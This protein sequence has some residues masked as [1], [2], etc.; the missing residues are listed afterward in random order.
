MIVGEWI[1]P[2]EV[3]AI[4]SQ[5]V[6][7][8]P[9]AVQEVWV[10]VEDM[11]HH[12]AVATW[13]PAAAVVL[14]PA[15][16]PAVS[17]HQQ[18]AAP[19]VAAAVHPTVAVLAAPMAAAVAA[20]ARPTVAAV[21]LTE[22]VAARR[23]AHAVAAAPIVAVAHAAVPAVVAAMVDHREVADVVADHDYQ[24]NARV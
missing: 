8:I 3:I 21:V 18:A 13:I 12:V 23:V 7:L 16:I 19:M 1:A 17:V 5:P 24:F 10:T 6:E 20:V 22:A 15:T 14:Q 11:L 4:E 2:Q 9:V